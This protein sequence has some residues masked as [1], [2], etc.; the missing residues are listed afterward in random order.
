MAVNKVI[1]LGNLGAD[2]KVSRPNQNTVVASFAMA[3]TEKGYTSKSGNVIPDRTEWHNVVVWNRMAEVAERYLRKGMKVYV[4]GKLRTRS[5]E[6]GAGVTRYVTEVF[7]EV[8][9]MVS[10]PQ[11]AQQAQ[12]APV[13]TAAPV[14]NGQHAG[15][16]LPF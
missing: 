10:A 16:Y 13:P 11:Q 5:Y 9:E 14:Q 3:T 1:L 6:D 8:L 2:P 15:G 12:A 4:E 7:A